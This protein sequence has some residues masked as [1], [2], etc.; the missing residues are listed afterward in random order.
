MK[1]EKVW[2]SYSSYTQALTEHSRKLAFAV[3]AICWFFKSEQ[4]TFPPA[5][6]VA[7]AFVVLYFIFDV[8][9]YFIA[10]ITL[11]RWIYRQEALLES[12]K[13][14][15]A[16]DDEVDKP[17]Y[18]DAIPYALFCSKIVALFLSFIMLMWEFGTR[19]F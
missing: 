11:K 9:Q 7:L 19:L 3:A 15:A 2:E 18:L 1:V 17:P 8:L 14:K 4:V 10:A 13:G 12:E 6:V 16:P 5:I